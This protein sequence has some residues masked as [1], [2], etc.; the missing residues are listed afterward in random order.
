MQLVSEDL[1]RVIKV[2]KEA[3]DKSDF[4]PLYEMSINQ[5]HRPVKVVNPVAFQVFMVL[6]QSIAG[7]MSKIQIGEK[8]PLEN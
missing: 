6:V 5:E 1:T 4:G 7:N 3:V 8:S 2:C